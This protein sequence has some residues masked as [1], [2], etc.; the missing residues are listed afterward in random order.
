MKTM[1]ILTYL[2]FMMTFVSCSNQETKKLEGSWTIDSIEIN[3][4]DII[5]QFTSNIITF[6]KDNACILPQPREN[7]NTEGKWKINKKNKLYYIEILSE[8]NKLNGK[9]K[10]D[11]KND[12]NEQLLK[13][14]LLSND[15]KIVCTKLFHKFKN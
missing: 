1:K 5:S 8:G 10:I 9:Y 15:K 14:Y 6:K 13:M 11:F 12:T 4:Q 2:V 7:N 3:G